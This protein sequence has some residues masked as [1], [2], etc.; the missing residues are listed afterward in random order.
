MITFD[1]VEKMALATKGRSLQSSSRAAFDA[2][3]KSSLATRGH[4]LES[5]SV[6]QCVSNPVVSGT[7]SPAMVGQVLQS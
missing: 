4:P 7:I 1:I 3:G 2:V 5:S 6:A